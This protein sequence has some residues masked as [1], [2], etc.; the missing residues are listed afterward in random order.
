[1]AL[2]PAGGAFAVLVVCDGVSSSP[3]S[4]LASLAAARAA[5]R[6]LGGS[7]DSLADG[8]GAGCAAR[9]PAAAR[10]PA[11]GASDAIARRSATWPSA[12]DPPSCTFVAAVVDG[13][14]V[15]AG[16]LGDSR[17]YW[18]PDDGHPLQL[19]SD[20]SGATS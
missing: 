10:R 13:P 15:V 7:R 4:D 16:W 5:P 14:H 8:H 17:V 12:H 2:G 3:G 6:V 20:D 18:L 9:G 11:S 19:S 1:M